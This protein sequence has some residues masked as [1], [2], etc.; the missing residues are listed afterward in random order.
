MGLDEEPLGEFRNTD[1]CWAWNEPQS[2][3][4]FSNTF[5]NGVGIGQKV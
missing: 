2:R 1:L 5:I 3:F 4:F